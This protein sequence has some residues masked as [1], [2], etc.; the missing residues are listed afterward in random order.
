MC[1][2]LQNIP[3]HA[4]QINS[5]WAPFAKPSFSSRPPTALKIRRLFTALWHI[6]YSRTALMYPPLRTVWCVVSL[7]DQGGCLS[8]LRWSLLFA[9]TTKSHTCFQKINTEWSRVLGI[10]IIWFPG[11]TKTGCGSE[12][13]G[14]Q[15]K[16]TRDA[17]GTFPASAMDASGPVQGSAHSGEC[18]IVQWIHP[19]LDPR[20]FLLVRV[21]AHFML[22][23][24]S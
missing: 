14:E 8:E 23:N 9:D 15:A 1:P 16:S 5:F 21:S 4:R 18:Q 10:I 17:A 13:D 7:G 22:T 6:I 3:G 11:P 20:A 12:T 19:W 2:L 24:F